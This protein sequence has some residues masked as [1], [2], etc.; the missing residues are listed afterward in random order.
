M[1]DLF[2]LARFSVDVCGGYVL[3][4]VQLSC[5]F[6]VH[7][8]VSLLGLWIDCCCC[9]GDVMS[10][11]TDII[12]GLQLLTSMDVVVVYFT[13]QS[14]SSCSHPLFIHWWMFIVMGTVR[15]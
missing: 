5:H 15:N 12:M 9:H 8:S 14:G 2:P 1:S 7:S 10:C 3:F 4:C 13:D 11:L 6:H